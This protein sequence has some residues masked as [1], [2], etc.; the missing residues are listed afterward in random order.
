MVPDS[1]IEL[2]YGKSKTIDLHNLTKEDAKAKLIY[3]MGLVD[4]DV[5]CLIIVH[6]YHGGTVIKNLVKKEFSH[7]DIQEKIVLDAGRT[8]FLLKK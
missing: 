5:K 6:G 2:Y 3:E 7:P 1:F 4:A 8:I